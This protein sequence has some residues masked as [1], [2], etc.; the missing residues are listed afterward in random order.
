MEEEEEEGKGE[1]EEEGEGEKDR[2]VKPPE[3]LTR[4]SL[5][6]TPSN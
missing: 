5:E 4:K 3:G 6:S 2:N 1:A